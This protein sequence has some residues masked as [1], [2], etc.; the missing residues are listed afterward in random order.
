MENTEQTEPIEE[1]STSGPYLTKTLL[2]GT[3]NLARLGYPLMVTCLGLGIFSGLYFLRNIYVKIT[4]TPGDF[5]LLEGDNALWTITL[6]LQA[7]LLF[8]FTRTV[9]NGLNAW[10]L[11]RNCEEDDQ[12]LLQGFELLVQMFRWAT[13]MV[14]LYAAAS[15]IM[16][17][18]SH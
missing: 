10:K 4:E 2:A 18:L 1:E 7:G 9:I 16:R 5:Y 13:L 3:R 14:L 8:L 6:V 17:L 11:L 12:D 15:I